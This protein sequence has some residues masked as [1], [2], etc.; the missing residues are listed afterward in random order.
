MTKVTRDQV[1]QMKEKDIN[2]KM[3]T[4]K[5]PPDDYTIGEKKEIVGFVLLNSLNMGLMAG[6]LLAIPLSYL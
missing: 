2:R 3:Q 1:N 4:L 6:S 5:Y